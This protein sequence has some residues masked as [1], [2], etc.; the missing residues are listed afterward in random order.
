MN[1]ETQKQVPMPS[2]RETWS[3]TS[4]AQKPQ[5]QRNLRGHGKEEGVR[6]DQTIHMNDSCILV[7][8]CVYIV[9]WYE[10]KSFQCFAVDSSRNAGNCIT[11]IGICSLC[12]RRKNAGTL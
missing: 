8:L 11:E 3:A 10:K 6:E 2:G 4:E 7:N 9:C 12:A 1:T 5:G